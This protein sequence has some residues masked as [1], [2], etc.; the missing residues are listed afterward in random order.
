[1]YTKERN[2][3]KSK[4]FDFTLS[5]PTPNKIEVSGDFKDI[6]CYINDVIP[7][8]EKKKEKTDTDMS[9]LWDLQHMLRPY[10]HLFKPKNN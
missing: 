8:L 3:R 10:T 7:I 2:I 4:G 5:K 1:M 6:L 9:I